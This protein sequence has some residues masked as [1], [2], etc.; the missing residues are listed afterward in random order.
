MVYN[1]RPW[2]SSETRYTV[3]DESSVGPGIIHVF[4][5]LTDESDTTSYLWLT[6]DGVEVITNQVIPSTASNYIIGF[7]PAQRQPYDRASIHFNEGFVVEGRRA[8][9]QDVRWRYIWQTIAFA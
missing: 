3:A 2:L 1:S 4:A 6:V 5:G 7:F 8:A 9:A